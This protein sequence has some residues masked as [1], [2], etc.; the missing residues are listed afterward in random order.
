MFAGNLAAQ[1]LEHERSEIWRTM[2]LPPLDELNALEVRLNNIS[3]ILH[4]M[5]HDDSDSTIQKIVTAAK[6]GALGKSI[7]TAARRCRT[8]SDQ[9]FR[10]RLQN[11]EKA[12][13]EQGWL[14]QCWSRS[15]DES[16]SVYWPAK[17]VAILFEID[18]FEE[19]M[20][21]IEDGLA[22]GQQH[23]GNDWKFT[24]APVMNGQIIASMAVQPSAHMPMPDLN[25]AQVWRGQIDTP[26][27]SPKITER[28]DEALNACAIISG[29]M[30][31]R[32]LDN[33]HPDEEQVLSAAVEAFEKSRDLVAQAAKDIGQEEFYWAEGF[34]RKI[35]N[36]IVS[37]HE[38]A[39]KGQTVSG[40][41]CMI[42]YLAL[43]GQENEQT[44]ELAAAR[45]LL[46]QAECK[47]ANTQ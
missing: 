27:F 26:F 37:E 21:Y 39:R 38:L 18:D 19:G 34:L 16:D 36:G 31:C 25:F 43:S 5:V 24:I 29:I 8:I 11:L 14:V 40:P 13:R 46:L 35:W 32:D 23:I 45:M 12:F 41:Q 10:K 30:Y 3:Y 47:N 22:I 4:E 9:R 17:E 33:L 7:R 28:I 42:P 20:P 44:S 15:L 1:A 2:S 6:K